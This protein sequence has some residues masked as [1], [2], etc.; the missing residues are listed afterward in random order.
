MEISQINVNESHRRATS[1]FPGELA[2]KNLPAN[3][4][5][6][7]SIPDPGVSHMPQSS[8]AHAPQ[9]LSQRSRAGEPQLLHAGTTTTE[10]CTTRAHALQQEQNQLSTTRESPLKATKTQHGH[11]EMNT[12]K[13]K[14]GGNLYS[15]SFIIII[16]LN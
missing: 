1:V 16:I 6:T 12:F 8:W 2:A 14:I 4:V 13:K 3:T 7:G 5:D 9:L 15:D 11:K 10:A